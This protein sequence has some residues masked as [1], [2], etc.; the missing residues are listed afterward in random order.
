MPHVSVELPGLTLTNEPG[1][2]DRAFLVD[3]RNWH[4]ASETKRDSEQRENGLGL[5]RDDDPEEAGRYP[6]IYGR[7]LSRRE[8]DEWPLRAA[9]MALKNHRTF[10]L[11]VTDPTGRWRSEV[12]VSG[13]IVFDIHDD[14]WCDFEIPL[15]AADPRK[16]GPLQVITVGP[17]SEGIGMSDP[18]TD[19]FDEGDPGNPGRAVCVN[20]GGAPTEPVVK[21]YGGVSEGFELLCL[22]H[23]RVVRVT[24][25][26]PPESW[27]TV[28]MNSGNVWIDD[29]SILPATYTPTTQWFQI[30]AGE[31]CTI[32]WAPLGIQTGDPR[33][34]V[35]FS[36]ADW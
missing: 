5:Y 12:A 8:G 20:K 18:F 11:A 24:R 10:E 13:R 9:V 6:I 2:R 3:I 29:Q 4:D 22:E 15:E 23:A 26:I 1:Q 31:M 25:P 33:M 30:A 34:R 35:E 32:Q 28:D 19:P 21:V 27:V 14:G 17:P 16:Y 7:L 36:E